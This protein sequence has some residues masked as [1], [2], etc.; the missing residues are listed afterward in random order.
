MVYCSAKLVASATISRANKVTLSDDKPTATF[1]NRSQRSEVKRG[2]MEVSPQ[3]AGQADFPLLASG[4]TTGTKVAEFSMNILLAIS[5][6]TVFVAGFFFVVA[7]RVEVSAVKSNTSRVIRELMR[8]MKE[9]LDT[10]EKTAIRTVLDQH[11]NVPDL[12][13]EDDEVAAK[14]KTLLRNTF[15]VLSGV[16]LACVLVVVVVWAAMRHRAGAS[17]R[18]GVNYPGLKHLVVENLIL[19]G[20][21]AGVEFL[22]MLTVGAHY[23]S[24]DSN[25]IRRSALNTLIDFGD[26]D[27]K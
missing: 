14:N 22:F 10:P 3:V 12:S 23:E 8:D 6:F 5:M 21:V 2:R 1:K 27:G 19:L 7:S 18:A 24:I 20:F 13:E 11:L 9:T 16:F 17:G 25:H 4:K 15:L 26:S